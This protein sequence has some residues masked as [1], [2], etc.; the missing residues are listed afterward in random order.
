MGILSGIRIISVVGPQGSGKSAVSKILAHRL[1][2]AFVETSSVVTKVCGDI[3][4]SDMPKTNERTKVEPTWLGDAITSEILESND[5]PSVVLS[6]VR[7]H[8][9]HETLRG[10][11]A[12]III[13]LLIANHRTRL[14]RQKRNRKCKNEKE[15]KKHDLNELQIGLG[16]VMA[17]AHFREDTSKSPNPRMVVDKIEDFLENPKG[18]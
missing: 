10:K 9:I 4:R 6:G 8:E 11:G 1:N 15:F 7:E 16:H 14:T 3:P 13:I 18:R 2:A 17:T 12:E 5:H